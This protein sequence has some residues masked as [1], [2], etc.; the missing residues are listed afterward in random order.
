MPQQ[1]DRNHVTRA[2]QGGRGRP[3]SPAWLRTRGRGG[4]HAQSS[5][6][7]PLVPGDPFTTHVERGP[8]FPSEWSIRTFAYKEKTAVRWK[9]LRFVIAYKDA[10]REH[11]IVTCA[12]I[13]E[14]D[15]AVKGSLPDKVDGLLD[16]LVQLTK[17]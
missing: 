15:E 2:L 9:D 16:Q 12:P 5:L 3:C 4:R 11:V 1:M 10:R 7:Q 14:E 17:E 8:D 6:L 13:H